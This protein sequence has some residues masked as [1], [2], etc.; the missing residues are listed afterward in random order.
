MLYEAAYAFDASNSIL[1]QQ[2]DFG[3]FVLLAISLFVLAS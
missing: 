2:I 3:E 1:G